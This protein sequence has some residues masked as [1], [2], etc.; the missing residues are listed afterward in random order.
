MNK[1]I[2]I[3][4]LLKTLIEI[5]YIYIYIYNINININ[6]IDNLILHKILHKKNVIKNAK[7]VI[8]AKRLF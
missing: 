1:I 8:K 3:E 6:K 7:I 4:I 2:L 5:V